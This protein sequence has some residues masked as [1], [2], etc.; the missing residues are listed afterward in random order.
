MQ[1]LEHNHLFGEP[2]KTQIEH[3]SIW[4]GF[5]FLVDFGIKGFYNN[6]YE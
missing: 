1:K 6:Y 5:I 4:R 2:I 3:L